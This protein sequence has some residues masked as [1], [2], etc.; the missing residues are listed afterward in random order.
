MVRRF[1]NFIPF[2]TLA[3]AWLLLLFIN[4]SGTHTTGGLRNLYFS[5]V[6]G[7]GRTVWTMYN[8]CH[9]AVDGTVACTKRQ[10]AFPFSPADNFSDGSEVPEHFVQHRKMYYNT[11]RAGYAFY[12][13]AL[14]VA[15]LALIQVLVALCYPG[16]FV[17][18]HGT[19]PTGIALLFAFIAAV[20]KTAIHARGV[21]YFRAAGYAAALG[22][23]MAV[24][25]WLAVVFLLVSLLWIAVFSLGKHTHTRHRNEG[26]FEAT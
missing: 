7:N 26:V 14:I 10:A 3:A 9:V 23:S 2:V 22:A 8:S 20:L 16:F 15:S 11:S 5:S 18:A 6:E 1:F 17:G 19:A 25:M 12:L 4:I 24:C 13:M 21:H